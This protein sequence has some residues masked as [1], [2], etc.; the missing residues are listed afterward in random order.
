MPKWSKQTYKMLQKNK[1]LA[2]QGKQHLRKTKQRKTHNLVIIPRTTTCPPR[3]TPRPPSLNTDNGVAL[4]KDTM[5]Y[6]GNN[7]KGIGTLH[8]SNAVPV[9]TDAEAR[10]QATM[11]R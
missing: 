6:T 10:D 9:F 1:H 4:K 11:R 5:Y 2:K 8:K 3:D 7:V